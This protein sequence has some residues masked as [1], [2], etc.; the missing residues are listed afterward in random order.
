[1]KERAEELPQ[2]VLDLSVELELLWGRI[3]LFNV[4]SIAVSD[5]DFNLYRHDT[6]L[7]S[8]PIWAS[9]DDEKELGEYLLNL[10]ME[11]S[12]KIDSTCFFKDL[13]AEVSAICLNDLQTERNT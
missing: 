6:V 11:E 1:M 13:K 5:Q 2:Q 7:N 10:T 9:E 12:A 3:K 8:P 4:H